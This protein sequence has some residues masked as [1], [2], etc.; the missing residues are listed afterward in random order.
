M[1][2]GLGLGLAG[3]LASQTHHRLAFLPQ[4]PGL[5]GIKVK[6][7]RWQGDVLIN[8]THSPWEVLSLGEPGSS[9]LAHSRESWVR[10]VVA[11]LLSVTQSRRCPLP[12]G[13]RKPDLLFWP[14]RSSLIRR[15]GQGVEGGM[16]AS[17]GFEDEKLTPHQATI[18]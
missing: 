2:R 16:G 11:V 9:R 7:D 14:L 1:R 10:S 17:D 5:E 3:P 15:E 8:S 4:R 6:C 12:A 18:I 13:G